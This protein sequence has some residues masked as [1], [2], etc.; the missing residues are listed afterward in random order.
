MA[1]LVLQVNSASAERS[2]NRVVVKVECETANSRDRVFADATAN[3]DSADVYVRAESPGGFGTMMT[4]PFSVEARVD[5]A[6]DV[7]TVRI[8]SR[9]GVKTI[10]VG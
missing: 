6:P 7:K 1:D 8:H 2:G 10:R 4:G 5:G 3:G 9:N